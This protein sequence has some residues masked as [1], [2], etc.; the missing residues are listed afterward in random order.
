[1]VGISYTSTTF[2]TGT[3][4]T[5]WQ[6]ATGISKKQNEKITVAMALGPARL[7]LRIAT[8]A[9]TVGAGVAMCAILKQ[10][11]ATV[12]VYPVQFI[13]LLR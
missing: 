3:T 2:A 4:D 8:T 5:V 9:S 6:T 12:L 7:S 1:M 10:Y 13:V 11:S